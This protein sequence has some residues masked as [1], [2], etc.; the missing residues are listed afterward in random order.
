M[1]TTIGNWLTQATG[2]NAY[3]MLFLMSMTPVVET[4]GAVIFM[5][6]L[7]QDLGQIFA[8]LWCCIA[9]SSAVILPLVL[10]TRPLLARLRRTRAFGKFASGL[11]GH[12]ALKASRAIKPSKR[13]NKSLSSN[14]VNSTSHFHKNGDFNKAAA[15]AAFVAIP[16]PMTGVWTGSCIGGF[17]GLP[18]W[19]AALA[20]F[21]GNVIAAHIILALCMAVPAELRD[22]LLYAF[23]ALAVAATVCTIF[24]KSKRTERKPDP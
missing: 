3:L 13:K 14:N 1:V 20:V 12:F 15:L 5:T 11:E 2:G 19:N 4:R 6:G 10:L 18:V 7:L 23:V 9:G 21:T 8:G 22:I 24:A 17:C 16:L